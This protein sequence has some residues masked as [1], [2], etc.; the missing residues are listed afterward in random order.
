MHMGY[1]KAVTHLYRDY[2]HLG[3]LEEMRP[4]SHVC[5]GFER[6]KKVMEQDGTWIQRVVSYPTWY[7]YSG[8]HRKLASIEKR[9]EGHNWDKDVLE[10]ILDWFEQHPVPH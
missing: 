1:D 2:V 3:D 6:Y 8:L 5:K 4:N 9:I 10:E 7:S